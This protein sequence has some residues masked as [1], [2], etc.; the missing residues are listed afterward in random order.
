MST[1]SRVTLALTVAVASALSASASAAE[2]TV[3]MFGASWCG[4]CAA[5]K[6]FLEAVQVPF[7]YLDVDDAKNR[8]AFLREGGEGGIPYLVIGTEKIRGANLPKITDALTRSGAL[9]ARPDLTSRGV[10]LYGGQPAEWWQAQ[11]RELR[12]RI[13]ALDDAVKSAERSAQFDDEKATVQ[14]MKQD[15]KILEASVDQL[16]NDASNVSL[17]R[18]Y[19]E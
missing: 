6:Q 15:K 9:R 12:A 13:A 5:V 2:P 16:E 4:P 1:S 10:D 11:F 18:K 8:E 17:P 19:R 3:R 7:V 14:R